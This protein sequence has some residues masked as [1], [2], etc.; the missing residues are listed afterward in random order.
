MI[1]RPD[2][3]KGWEEIKFPASLSLSFYKMAAAPEMFSFN[4]S[5]F[6]FPKCD[7]GQ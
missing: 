6:R 3:L 5:H 1:L 2:L 7:G 4:S